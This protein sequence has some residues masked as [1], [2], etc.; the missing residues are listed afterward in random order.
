MKL[1]RHEECLNYINKFSITSP[2]GLDK[3]L[4]L[5]A[6][7]LLKLNRKDESYEALKEALEIFPKSKS[8]K[9]NIE[10]LENDKKILNN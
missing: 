6:E 1:G 5:K 4:A 10:L 2:D 3:I 9:R 8:L 7:C